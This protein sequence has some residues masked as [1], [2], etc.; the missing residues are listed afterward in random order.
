M[1]A[2][3]ETGRKPNGMGE[4][5]P[6]C[7]CVKTTSWKV[8]TKVANLIRCGIGYEIA[9]SIGNARQSYWRMA[10]N[11]CVHT[12][13]STMNLKRAGYSCLMDAYLEWYPK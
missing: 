13:I 8:K 9:Q 2:P 11:Y 1:A 5:R 3:K 6:L 4:C 7:G 10:K 12:A